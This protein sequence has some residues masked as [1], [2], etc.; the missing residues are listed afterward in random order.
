MGFILHPSLSPFVPPTIR[1]PVSGHGT[2]IV[3][4]SKRGAAKLQPRGQAFID[5]IEVQIHA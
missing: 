5:P 1:S 2:T 4:Y 3:H